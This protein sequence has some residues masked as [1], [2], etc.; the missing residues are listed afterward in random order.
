MGY[1]CGMDFEWDDFKSQ[2][3]FHERGFD[4]EYV[5]QTFFDHRRSITPDVRRAYGED[6]WQ[7]MGRVDGRLFIVVYTLRG[8]AFRIISARKANQREVRL[9]EAQ[10][11][12]D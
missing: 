11:S 8:E 6:R 7:L 3:C 4:F 9:Y 2:V 12:G 10:T 1:T 5:A